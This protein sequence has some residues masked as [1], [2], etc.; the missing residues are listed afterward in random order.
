MLTGRQASLP[1]V[2]WP[3]QITR[4]VALFL[5]VHHLQQQGSTGGKQAEP[6]AHHQTHK[7]AHH[8]GARACT[9]QRPIRQHH[10]PQHS[11]HAHA[12][13]RENPPQRRLKAVKVPLPNRSVP[14]KQKVRQEEAEEAL[15]M[16]VKV[17]A[18]GGGEDGEGEAKVEEQERAGGQGEHEL[19]AELLQLLLEIQWAVRLSLN[20]CPFCGGHYVFN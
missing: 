2:L 3:R 19:A 13:P 17:R 4:A 6:G 10:Q 15:Q 7:D 16:R 20:D 1:T 14:F 8:P 5:L 9:H 12:R 18:L 11:I